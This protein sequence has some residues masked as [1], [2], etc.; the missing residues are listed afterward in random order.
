[1]SSVAPLL[2]TGV[3]KRL[4]SL[5]GAPNSELSANLQTEIAW[6]LTNIAG[7]TSA[8]T[9]AVVD[10]DAVPT[11]LKLLHTSRHDM[12]REQVMWALGNIACDSSALRDLVLAQGA[13]PLV[14]DNLAD[15]SCDTLVR[16]NALWVLSKLCGNTPPA[17]FAVVRTAYAVLTGFLSCDNAS[18][19]TDTCAS[20]CSVAVGNHDN[21]DELVATGGVPRFAALLEHHDTALQ[22]QALRCLSYIASGNADHVRQVVD[23]NAL[24]A[25][26]RMLGAPDNATCRTACWAFGNIAHHNAEAVAAAGVAH[27]LAE[28]ARGQVLDIKKKAR[29]ALLKLVRKV[30]PDT[31]TSLVD[32]DLLTTLLDILSTHDDPKML[33]SAL[34]CINLTL[35]AS[36]IVPPAAPAVADEGASSSSSTAPSLWSVSLPRK[37]SAAYAQIFA[38]H[39]GMRSVEALLEHTDREVSAQS[40]MI[41]RKF[42]FSVDEEEQEAIDSEQRHAAWMGDL[43]SDNLERV[44]LG[45]ATVRSLCN[46][47]APQSHFEQRLVDIL[48]LPSVSTQLEATDSE[49]FGLLRPRMHTPRQNLFAKRLVSL[50]A[51]PATTPTL[52]SEIL[53]VLAHMAGATMG[54]VLV[55][56]G[57]VEQC[58]TLMRRGDDNVCERA[59]VALCKLTVESLTLRD[60]VLRAGAMAVVLDRVG[61]MPCD[62]L[63]R[64]SAMNLIM[65]M[66]AGKPSPEFSIVRRAVPVASAIVMHSDHSVLVKLAALTLSHLS[67]GPNEKIQVVVDSGA[68]P[69][70]VALLDHSEAAVQSAALRCIGNVVSGNEHQTQRVIDAGGLVPLRK[71][72]LSAKGQLLK[73][74]CWSFS[75]VTAGTERQ[76]Q[77]VL[78]ND[79]M[80]LILAIAQRETSAVRSEAGWTIANAAVSGTA[81]QVETLVQCGVIAVIVDLLSHTTSRLV[82]KLVE[83]LEAIIGFNARHAVLVQQCGGLLRI[84]ALLGHS[85]IDVRDGASRLFQALVDSMP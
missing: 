27:R 46:A 15:M 54:E 3:V 1:M 65:Q 70:L 85:S 51:L 12:V 67:D 77:A 73:E 74:T 40:K 41:L 20:L 43:L 4:V 6:I 45:V 82:A 34:E 50:L 23:S 32:E 58:V 72:L 52:Q 55:E 5:L 47:R 18:I 83:A 44:A 36:S 35:R 56:A 33:R 79:V 64:C 62:E 59:I 10:A 21:I 61:D 19:L 78:D 84:E 76:I 69:R 42:N 29:F 8:E 25:I 13:M 28:L 66:C 17:P 80:P 11:F 49:P 60:R 53:S 31:L 30:P 37:I 16:C 71:L 2:S 75:N 81:A 22:F 68:V 39:N 63:V 24:P 48:H 14:L 7:G 57:A 9:R 38:T 26:A